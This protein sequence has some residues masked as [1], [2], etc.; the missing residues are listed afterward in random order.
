MSMTGL[1]ANPG[2]GP[3]GRRTAA[4]RRGRGRSLRCRFP[5]RRLAPPTDWRPAAA[6][7]RRTTRS[8]HGWASAQS[9]AAALTRPQAAWLAGLV[10]APSADDPL[11]H[12]SLARAREAHVLDRL[13]A[14]GML[15]QVQAE[16]DY[17]QP[18]HL[19]VGRT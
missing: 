9:I 4:A 18:L 8:R 11:A 7:S 1:A 12:P 6:G 15:T 19:T 10:Q 17:Q 3:R 16:R 2:S 14:T 5:A 13:A